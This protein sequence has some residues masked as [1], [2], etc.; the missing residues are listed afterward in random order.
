MDDA[1]PATPAQRAGT[2][3]ERREQRVPALRQTPNEPPPEGG[4]ER[5]KARAGGVT[6]L[7]GSE[8]DRQGREGREGIV[9]ARRAAATPGRSRPSIGRSC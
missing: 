9:A 1:P 8:F 3:A 4:D 6:A 2:S 7:S 5:R